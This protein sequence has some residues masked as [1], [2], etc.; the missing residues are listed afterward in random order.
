MTKLY[1]TACLCLIAS[2]CSKGPEPGTPATATA[3]AVQIDR[4]EPSYTAAGTAFKALADG[5]SQLVVFGSVPDGSAVLWNDQPMPSSGGGKGGFV[6]GVIP[7]NLI[8]MAGTARVTVRSG[9]TTS[10]ALDFTIYGKTGPVP[11]ITALAPT[12]ALAGKGFGVQPNGDSALGIRGVGFLPG[13]SM[14]VDGKPMNTVF[15]HDDF[16]STV[17]PKGLVAKAGTHQV[18]AKNPDKKISNKVEFKV[19]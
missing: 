7:A 1:L 8:Q 9:S 4:L 16:L 17:I 10:N 12:E 3:P 6:V 11:Q 18:W 14:V 15:G 5:T 13:V 2:G 19:N